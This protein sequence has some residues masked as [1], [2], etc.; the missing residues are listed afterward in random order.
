MY[1]DYTTEQKALRDRIRAYMVELCTDALM[2]ELSATGGGGPL[3]HQAMQKLA[4]DEWLGIG[5]PK[6]FGGKGAGPIEQF[7]FFDEVQGSGFPVPILTLNTVGPIIQKFGTPEQHA[8]YLPRILEGK[9]HFS[10]G[11][12]EPSAGT[13]LASLQCRAVRDGD[14]YVIN[15]Q[16]TWTSL[17]DHADYLWLAVRTDT[18]AA[19]HKG[20]SIMIVPADAPGV[21]IT[22]IDALGDNNLHTMFFEDVRVPKS[23][24]VGE[25]NKGW[26]L[27]TTQ[28]NHERVALNALAPIQSLMNDTAGWAAEQPAP[29]GGVLLDLSWVRANL[30]RVDAKLDVLRLLNWQQAWAIRDGSL[31]PADASALKV[32]GSEL[33]VEASRLLM[34]IHGA[35]GALK[36]GSPGAVLKGRL[37]KFYRVSLVLTFGGGTNEVQR[38]IISMVGLRMPR[39]VR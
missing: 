38:D 28:L 33:Y 2:D 8:K 22:P 31:S 4:A 35:A 9:C 32:Y 29:E 13:D 17:A 3:Y 5:W 11:Y 24:L 30:G 39:Q 1:L 15:G 14:D 25:E 19:P 27:I 26:T 34:E 23:A 20:I 16:K 7:I 6:E 21:T 36:R 12:S 37:E 10:I 18:E